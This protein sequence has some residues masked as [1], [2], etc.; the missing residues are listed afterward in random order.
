MNHSEIGPGDSEHDDPSARDLL[1]LY[2]RQASRWFYATRAIGLL[3]SSSLSEHRVDLELYRFSHFPDQGRIHLIVKQ[4]P[5]TYALAYGKR[6]FIKAKQDL[7]KIPRTV[8]NIRNHFL[9]VQFCNSLYTL[10]K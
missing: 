1:D 5:V 6:R 9:P 7:S 2:F 10:K 4:K 3:T 8:E